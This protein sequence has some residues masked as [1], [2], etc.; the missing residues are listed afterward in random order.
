MVRTKIERRLVAAFITVQAALLCLSVVPV[1]A[2]ARGYTTTDSGL[3]VGMIVALSTDGS[4]R[5]ERATTTSGERIVGVVTTFEKSDVTVASKESTLLVESTGE[6]D[7][8]VSDISGKVNQGDSL[9]VSPL[10]GV[11]MKANQGSVTPVVAIAASSSEGGDASSYD[12]TENGATKS[13]QI[14]KIKVNL[15]RKGVSGGSGPDS[16]SGLARLGRSL[17]GKEV[18]EIRV[19]AALVIF[20][21]VLVAEG[22][23]IYGAVSSAITALGRNPMARNIIRREMFRVIIIAISVLLVGLGAVY[24]VLWV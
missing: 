9:T 24:A 8:Y 7:A 19:L 23:I 22:G 2:I 13:T 14:T 12:Y 10:K 6:V 20:I 3:Q 1:N 4:S 21:I 18:G 15:D 11:L 5:V 17:T 16:E